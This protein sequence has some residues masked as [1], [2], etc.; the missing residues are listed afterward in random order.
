MGRLSFNLLTF[1]RTVAIKLNERHGLGQ[2]LT[3]SDI[4]QICLDAD[5]AIPGLNSEDQTIEKAPMQIGKIMK[6]LFKDAEGK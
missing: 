6:P 5:I 2:A 4:S 3:A 1:L